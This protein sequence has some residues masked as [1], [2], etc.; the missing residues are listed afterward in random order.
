VESRGGVPERLEHQPALDGLRAVAVLVVIFFH[1][2]LH[3]LSWGHYFRGGFLGVDLFFV[4]S[5]FLITSLLLIDHGRSGSTISR[6]FWIRRA[7]R[8][9]RRC[10]GCS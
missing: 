3:D 9:I 6:R 2:T 8:L 4:L 7:R 1:F 10:S 5:G